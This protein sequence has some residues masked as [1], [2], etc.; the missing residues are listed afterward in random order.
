M[1]DETIDMS[2]LIERFDYIKKTIDMFELPIE[3]EEG[4]NPQIIY[5]DKSQIFDIL[6]ILRDCYYVSLI[7]QEKG[8]D[9]KI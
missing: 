3:I 7:K 5:S 1:S 2:L 4:E 6:R 9:N 8:V